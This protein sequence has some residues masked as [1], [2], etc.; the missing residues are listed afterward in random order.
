MTVIKRLCAETACVSP[1]QK[2]CVEKLG[3]T[4]SIVKG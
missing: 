2:A 1:L 3:K 4:I